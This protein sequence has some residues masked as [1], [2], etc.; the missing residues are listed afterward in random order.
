MSY[1][2]GTIQD[3]SASW[4]SGIGTMMIKDRDTG[5]IESIPFENGPT[6]RALIAAFDCASPEHSIDVSKLKGQEITYVWDEFGI[7]LGG[8]T[9]GYIEEELDES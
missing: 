9:P 1:K 5:A 4:G 2:Y 3:I 6:C 7:M 8:F